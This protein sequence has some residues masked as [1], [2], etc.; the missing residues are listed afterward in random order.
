MASKNN[1]RQLSFIPSILFFLIV[2]CTTA[3]NKAHKATIT[4][5]LIDTTTPTKT[6]KPSPT[7][8][9]QLNYSTFTPQ[10]AAKCPEFGTISN[11]NLDFLNPP[12]L[13]SFDTSSWEEFD[14]Q[15]YKNVLDFI[16]I[17]GPGPLIKYAQT[18]PHFKNWFWEDVTND[19]VPEFIYPG[20]LYQCEEGRYKITL[21]YSH[22][23]WG[24]FPR[25]ENIGDWNRNNV[26]ELLLHEW[27]S[28]HGNSS[29]QL[30]EWDQTVFRELLPD[31]LYIHP[32]GRI[33]YKDVDND[34]AQEIIVI[35]GIQDWPPNYDIKTRNEFTYYKWNGRNYVEYKKE[36]SD[37]IYRFQAVQD[38]DGFMDTKQYDRALEFYK[39][40]ISNGELEW[41]SP[42]RETYM[43][44]RYLEYGLTPPVQDWNEYHQLASYA[45]FRMI[46]LYLLQD[47]LSSAQS[48][49][50][51]TLNYSSPDL[52][53]YHYYKIGQEFWDEYQVS[54]NI[55]QSCAKA[56]EY[57]SK[58]LELLTPLGS[59]YH[60]LQSKHYLPEYICPVG[61]R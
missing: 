3:Q 15:R 9:D 48:V 38:A 52:P 7:F 47:N 10:P 12:F 55:N 39:E 51:E 2:G 30:Y 14:R 60:G 59:D 57:A 21:S 53:G 49:Y 32:D 41:W 40:V 16:N 11:P 44:R 29:Y 18:Q 19:G 25:F 58:H 31:S 42:D 28:N 33:D 35:S 61:L 1:S 4:P 5:Q 24:G 54:K 36:Y 45:R 43:Q 50:V 23:A 13:K 8:F 6:L 34:G 56:I 46:L 27:T 17:Y 20:A 37:P 22:D 26:P